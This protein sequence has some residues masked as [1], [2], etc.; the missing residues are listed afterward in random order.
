MYRGGS[1]GFVLHKNEHHISMKVPINCSNRK[2]GVGEE[3]MYLMK[4]GD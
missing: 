4:T 1:I 2:E 3:E